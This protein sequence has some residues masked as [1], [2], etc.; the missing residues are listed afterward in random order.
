CI[1]CPNISPPALPWPKKCLSTPA[2]RPIRRRIS[3]S[4]ALPWPEHPPPLS[5]RF[6]QR[7]IFPIS[8]RLQPRLRH[9]AHGGGIDAKPLAA[10]VFR[11]IVK[12]M[13][14]VRVPAV[15]AHLHPAHTMAVI[16]LALH[17]AGG[18]RFGKARPPRARIIFIR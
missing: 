5:L 15:R 10:L 8:F 6:K 9:K 2:T 14:Q 17:G 18:N 1:S 13:P 16:R 11:P 3:S 12:H 7:Q 4:K